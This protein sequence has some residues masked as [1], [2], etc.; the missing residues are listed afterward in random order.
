MNRKID[1][2]SINGERLKAYSPKEQVERLQVL[3]NDTASAT[4]RAAFEEKYMRTW[5]AINVLLP[6][7]QSRAKENT[8]RRVLALWLEYLCDDINHFKDAILFRNKMIRCLDKLF[9]RGGYTLSVYAYPGRLY[10]V[11]AGNAFLRQPRIVEMHECCQFMTE[12]QCQQ[13]AAYLAGNKWAALR[14]LVITYQNSE[15]RAAEVEALFLPA[16]RKATIPNVYV[17]L[18]RNLNNVFQACN[19]AHF[20]GKM[21]RP[22]GLT[23][24]GTV[25]KRVMGSYNVQNDVLTVNRALDDP[26]VPDYVV[27]FI[28]Y[29]ELL[30][31]MLGVKIDSAGRRRAHTAEFR[32]YERAHPDYERA[33]KYIQRLSASLS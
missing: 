7:A 9:S 4:T 16:K 23:W 3:F 15:P 31:K 33:Q 30:H 21:P 6:Y 26:K 1:P 10:R 27:D 24:S 32:R 2:N 17:G 18:Y 19:E 5:D 20:E 12:E 13:F 8:D 25:N 29:H 22:A 28:M 11:S 14:K